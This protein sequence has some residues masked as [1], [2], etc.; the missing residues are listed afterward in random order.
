MK[1]YTFEVRLDAAMEITAASEAEARAAAHT[2][3]DCFDLDENFLAGFNAQSA[4]VK[5]GDVSLTPDDSGLTLT[6]CDGEYI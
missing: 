2:I 3:M 1:T 4:D 6:A 5:V